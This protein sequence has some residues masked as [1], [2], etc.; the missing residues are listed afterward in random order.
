[1]THHSK[2]AF[3]RIH[4]EASIKYAEHDTD[5]YSD[6]IIYNYSKYGLYFE[7]DQ[8]LQPE[9]DVS[10][11]MVNYARG[12]YGAEAY[13]SYLARVKWCKPIPEAGYSRYG[14]GVQIMEK[15]HDL[16]CN[17]MIGLNQACDMCG[18]VVPSESLNYMAAQISLCSHCD[19]HLE[20][21]PNG[22][23]KDNIQRFLLGNVI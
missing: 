16:R 1:M 13:R 21:F 17:E 15:S 5:Q 9:S 22:I 10:I 2:K 12:A 6:S 11:I 14:V 23:I 4:Q 7:P 18:A 3:P 20:A 8:K 19:K